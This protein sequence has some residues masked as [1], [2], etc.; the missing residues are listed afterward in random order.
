MT[1]VFTFQNQQWILKSINM[2]YFEIALPSQNPLYHCMSVYEKN[3]GK[4]RLSLYKVA[5]FQRF[6]ENIE[7]FLGKIK[8]KGIFP[9]SFL[10]AK[11]IRL[12]NLPC[13]P[14]QGMT[15]PM[16]IHVSMCSEEW[17]NTM[18]RTGGRGGEQVEQMCTYNFRDGDPA[19]SWDS[20]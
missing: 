11:H 13:L 7:K 6:G 2:R 18:T 9:M 10:S 1:L 3:L 19:F 15:V 16:P 20:D 4:G 17:T 14:L 8:S 12:Q 5:L